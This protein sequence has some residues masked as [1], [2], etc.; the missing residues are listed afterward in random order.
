MKQTDQFS[1]NHNH[2]IQEI[3]FTVQGKH[4]HSVYKHLTIIGWFEKKRIIVK[5]THF[6]ILSWG[7]SLGFN[8]CLNLD[9]NSKLSIGAIWHVSYRLR[10][11]SHSSFLSHFWNRSLYGDIFYRNYRFLNST[12]RRIGIR[13]KANKN[14]IF[15]D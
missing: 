11:M 9:A 5:D 6:S 10:F 14:F 12:N 3:V 7:I 4:F 13:T 1:N 2:Y 15:Y 8:H